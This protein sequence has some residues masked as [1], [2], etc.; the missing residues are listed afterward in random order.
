MVFELAKKSWFATE[1]TQD[2]PGSGSHLLS[3]IHPRL[4]TQSPEAVVRRGGDG[5]RSNM[6]SPASPSKGP[7]RDLALAKAAYSADDVE[8]MVAAH[9]A[10]VHAAEEQHGGV[11]SDV[12]KSLVFGGLDGIVT[13]FAIVSAAVGAGLS[14]KTVIIMGVANL[15]ADAISMG[16]GDALS[17]K[18]EMDYV[19]REHQREKWEMDN[20]PK[21]E[22]EEMVELYTEK[23]VTEEDAR[24]IINTF[25]KYSDL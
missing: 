7:S 9:D 8:L 5:A 10:R 22:I 1:L 4:V 21:G 23:G 16:L 2:E 6:A 14:Q 13:T 15:V 12:I 20:N 11:G 19:K 3:C 25:A 18:A 17:E 24:L